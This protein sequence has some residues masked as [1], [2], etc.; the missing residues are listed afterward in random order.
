MKAA[1]GAEGG[2]GF[3][4][5]AASGGAGGG[6]AGGCVADFAESGLMEA[7]GRLPPSMQVLRLTGNHLEQLPHVGQLA[8][9]AQLRNLLAGANRIRST[10]PVLAAPAL[11]H[12]GLS[13]NQI[14]SLADWGAAAAAKSTLIS[15]DLSHNDLCSVEEAV[16]HLKALKS[17]ERLILAGNPLCLCRNYATR[18]TS[19]LPLLQTL[20]NE[21]V[22]RDSSPVLVGG[23]EDLEARGEIMVRVEV[24]D[25]EYS[26][27]PPSGGDSALEEGADQGQSEDGQRLAGE[28]FIEISVGKEATLSTRPPAVEDG[29][30]G[31]SAEADG[32]AGEAA[33]TRSITVVLPLLEARDLLREGLQATLVVVFQR[34]ESAPA[35]EDG[36]DLPPE[37]DAVSVTERVERVV[38]RG[39]F[40]APALV[41]GAPEEEG[42]LEFGPVPELID[43]SSIFMSLEDPRQPAGALGKCRVRVSLPV[44]EPA[45][46]EG[47]EGLN[48]EPVNTS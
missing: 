19:G 36:S 2:K 44:P 41:A 31:A 4:T 40:M 5:G 29:E 38:G 22:V 3:P 11:L 10:A 21:P 8:R 25:T 24:C 37:A 7:P 27:P 15:L 9:A 23:T 13:Y 33:G 47:A 14:A 39:V 12:A 16:K 6:G 17:L 20:D 30:V 48:T 42:V 34:D 26:P 18:V 46:P 35:V 45:D 32:D 28:F 43:E 1:G